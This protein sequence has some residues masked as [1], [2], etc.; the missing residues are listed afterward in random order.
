M[1]SKKMM[2]NKYRKRRKLKSVNQSQIAKYHN[3]K[4]LL[5]LNEIFLGGKG[6]ENFYREI[7]MFFKQFLKNTDKKVK[8]S[9]V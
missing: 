4:I 6:V 2:K 3:C 9:N 8:E 1:K 7:G 5:G